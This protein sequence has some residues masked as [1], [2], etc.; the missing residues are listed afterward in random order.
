MLGIK[1][2]ETLDL[3]SRLRQLAQLDA[4]RLVAPRRPPDDELST[5]STPAPLMS[6]VM[7]DVVSGGGRLYV[8]GASHGPSFVSATWLYQGVRPTE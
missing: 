5:P 7:S 8:L 2:E 3:T 1:H 4:P 6:W